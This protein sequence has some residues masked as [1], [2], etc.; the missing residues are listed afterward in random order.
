MAKACAPLPEW[1]EGIASAR[2]ELIRGRRRLSTVCFQQV[3]ATSD[4]QTSLGR[5]SLLTLHRR[6]ALDALTTASR[7][8]DP[9]AR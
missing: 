1:S 8:L 3:R 2:E 5:S 6:R 9:L 7:G 4:L